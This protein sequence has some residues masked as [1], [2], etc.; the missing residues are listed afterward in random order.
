VEVGN[1][2]LTPKNLSSVPGISPEKVALAVQTAN[3]PPGCAVASAAQVALGFPVEALASTPNSN[4]GVERT[5]GPLRASVDY[6]RFVVQEGSL[7][8]LMCQ[9]GGDV[10]NWVEGRG[11]HFYT[12]SKHCGGITIYHEGREEGMGICVQLSGAGCR[13]Y[14][15]MPG[16]VSWEWQFEHWLKVEGLHFTRIDAALDDFSG[17]VTMERVKAA[18]I[19]GHYV[20]RSGWDILETGQGGG[21]SDLPLDLRT[22]QKR[23]A[24]RHGCTVNFGSRTS[25]AMMRFYD[26]AAE[27]QAKGCAIEGE[28]VRAEYEAH[29]ERADLLAALFAQVSTPGA[30]E[31]AGV[32]RAF[33][34]FKEP[35][36]TDTNRRRWGSAWWWQEF[37]SNWEKIRLVLAPLVQTYQT[38]RAWAERQ[39][40]PSLAVL[41]EASGD[42]RKM[43]TELLRGGRDRWKDK[44][45]RIVRQEKQR[46]SSGG[47]GLDGRLVPA[48]GPTGF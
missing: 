14:E 22:S 12:Q 41:Y 24:S 43:I 10:E 21:F 1:L 33:I 19:A 8:L 18:A 47:V 20:C 38:I 13:E 27:R 36:E 11:G 15:S 4:T 37:L 35:S 31:V 30:P 23:G 39:L 16:F 40:A 42:G 32:M 34:D 26:K 2:H 48:S 46:L 17:L 44:H 3:L 9:F 29:D 25:S 5:E 6:C 7:P 45:R 28:W